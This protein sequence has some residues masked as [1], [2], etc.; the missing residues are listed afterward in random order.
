MY[1]PGSLRD[2][3]D[4]PGARTLSCFPKKL[5]RLVNDDSKSSL[6][7]TVP[8]VSAAPTVMIHSSE[9]GLASLPALLPSLPAAATTTMPACHARSTANP[10]GSSQA[11]G[12]PPDPYDRLITRIGLSGSSLRCFTTQSTAAMT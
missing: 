8:L 1:E 9:A 3:I 12:V 6:V 10:S 4:T 5:A 2:R 7:L 11:F